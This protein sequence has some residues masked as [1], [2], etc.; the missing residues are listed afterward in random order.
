MFEC[1]RC[2]KLV[3][4]CLSVKVCQAQIFK[5]ALNKYQSFMFIMVNFRFLIFYLNHFYLWIIHFTK[6]NFNILN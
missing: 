3:L 5:T 2:R 6:Y 4:K 1:F